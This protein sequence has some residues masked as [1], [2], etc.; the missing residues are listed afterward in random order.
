MQYEKRDFDFLAS[1]YEGGFVDVAVVRDSG[2]KFFGYL[3]VETAIEGGKHSSKKM[4]LDAN[5]RKPVSQT[6]EPLVAYYYVVVGGNPY[7][8]PEWLPKQKFSTDDNILQDWINGVRERILQY[9][10]KDIWQSEIDEAD[11]NKVYEESA[12]ELSKSNFRCPPIEDYDQF[13]KAGSLEKKRRRE[14]RK[15]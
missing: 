8:R 12:T 15:E 11:H 4:L 14:K 10:W 3:I 5:T 9:L 1:S 13:H 2:G 6:K 7:D